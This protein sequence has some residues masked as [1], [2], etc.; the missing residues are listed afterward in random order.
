MFVQTKPFVV[1]ALT[2]ALFAANAHAA[3][4][5]RDN[6]APVDSNGD[7]YDGTRMS[8][9]AGLRAAL[10]KHQDAF[11]RSFTERLMTYAV[12]RR[13]DYYDMPAIRAIVRD[14]ARSNNRFSAFVTGIVTSPAF[15][16]SQAEAVETSVER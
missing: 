8:G 11:I 7:L 9:P 2:A 13:V 16:M 6:G 1:G 3:Q 10:L 14:A 4:L 12:G 5:T 15:R